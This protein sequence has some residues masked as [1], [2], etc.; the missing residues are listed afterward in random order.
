MLRRAHAGGTRK[1]VATPHM[2]FDAFGNFDV[3]A[4]NDVFAR[5]VA[6][7]RRLADSP[8]H[9]FLWELDLRLG[10]ENYASLEFLEALRGL[11]VITLDGTRYLLVEF[12]LTLP[13]RQLMSVVRQ[14]L[15]SDLIPVLAHVERYSVVQK[16]P[17]ILE[18][19]LDAGCLSQVN[20]SSFLQ[21]FWSQRKRTAETLL[22]G[23]LISLIASDGHGIS[24]R[25]PDLREPF[26]RLGRRFAAG[27]L[28]KLFSD[29]PAR[30]LGVTP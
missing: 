10:A 9:E 29:S 14:V 16:D 20:G 11:E 19:L 18:K 2:F 25:P 4:V 13:A 3:S 1:V 15:E 7:L 22:K 6:G 17:A 30:I 26:L 12:P 8:G 5:T 23:D 24:Y 28:K 21:P 27:E